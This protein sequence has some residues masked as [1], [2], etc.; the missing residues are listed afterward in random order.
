MEETSQLAALKTV[1]KNDRRPHLAVDINGFVIDG[2]LDSGANITILGKGNDELV[3][4]L[5]IN[6]PITKPLSIRTADGTT[7]S[8]RADI[9]YTTNG[10]TKTVPTLLIPTITTQ[11][12]LG[13]DFWDAFNIR[14]MMCDEIEGERPPKFDPVNIKHEL[15]SDQQLQLN[16]VI[17][18]FENA[19]S[20]GILAVLT[21]RCT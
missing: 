9:P 7:H 8:T 15:S 14:P 16:E 12:I 21:V 20:D 1:P 3:K 17:N 5:K 4:S 6:A 18:T 11:L 19:P 10:T 2:L 13:T